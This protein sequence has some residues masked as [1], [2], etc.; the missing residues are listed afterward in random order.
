[1]NSK[2]ARIT[3]WV[4]SGLIAAFLLFSASGKLFIDFPDKQKMFDL[5]GWT[6]ER[7]KTV[8]VIEIL[9]TVIFLLPRVGFYGAIL[10]SAYLGGAV[11]THMRIGDPWFF[12]II[13]GVVVWVAL[14]LRQPTIFRLAACKE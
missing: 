11:C 6:V 14:G 10:L 12:P 8:G 3:G 13:I 2:A 1:M 4:L 7:M 5:F 9:F